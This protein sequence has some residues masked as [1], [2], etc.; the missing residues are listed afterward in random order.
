MEGGGWR[1]EGRGWRVEDGG[2][3]VEDGRWRVEGEGWRVEGGGWKVEGGSKKKITR[4][5]FNVSLVAYKLVVMTVLQCE[6]DWTT[7][8]SC[9]TSVPN[10][11]FYSHV[12][13]IGLK[14]CNGV[15]A[16]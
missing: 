10:A 16:F 6:F 9:T 14:T 15:Y 1:V 2:W 11:G 13:S 5:C 12:I 3:K 4:G 8:D 7:M